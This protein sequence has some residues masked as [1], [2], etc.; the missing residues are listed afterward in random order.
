VLFEAE[1]SEAFRDGVQPSGFRLVPQRIV[2]VGP[3]HDFLNDKLTCRGRTS[4]PFLYR[5]N[6][7]GPPCLLGPPADDDVVSSNHAQAETVRKV[8]EIVPQKHIPKLKPLH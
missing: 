6:V 1:M 4:Q 3:I 8:A 2:G 5:G 7:R